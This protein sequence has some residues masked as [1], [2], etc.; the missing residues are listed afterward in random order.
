LVGWE[1]GVEEFIR[2]HCG[3]VA[4]LDFKRDY[5][6]TPYP[7]NANKPYPDNANNRELVNKLYT[8]L[9]RLGNLISE[10]LKD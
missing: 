6:T 9:E 2:E 7:D 3:E 5:P 10:V 8:K 1:V 4:A